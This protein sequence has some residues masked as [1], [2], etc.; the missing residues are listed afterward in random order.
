MEN[1]LSLFFIEAGFFIFLYSALFNTA[2]SAT[3]QIHSE[4]AGIEP[5]TVANW[6]LAV[7]RF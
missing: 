2:L 1:N 3:P 7:E 4:D 6:A 5:R